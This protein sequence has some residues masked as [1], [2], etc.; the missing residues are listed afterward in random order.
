MLQFF[1]PVHKVQK[2]RKLMHD[3]DS[4]IAKYSRRGLVL[5]FLVFVL[6]LYYGNFFKA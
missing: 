3:T 5:N 1:T 2:D 4:R 6:C